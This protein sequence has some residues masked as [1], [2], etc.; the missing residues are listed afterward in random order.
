[1]PGKK[2]PNT[3]ELDP[4][5]DFLRSFWAL[6]HAIERVSIRMESVLGLTAQQRFVMRLVAKL[7]GIT[8]GRLAE[9]LHVDPGSITAVLK[10]LEQREFIV[11]TP[12]A[13]DRRRITLTLSARGRKLN[14]PS[15]VSVEHAVAVAL[16]QTTP[17]DLAAVRRIVN[18]LV[19]ALDQV[20]KADNTD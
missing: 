11:R 8:P 20:S 7:P 18:R 10:R 9:L 16:E 13:I 12:D 1:M 2:E 14:A 5:L 6:N 19:A 15:P 17:A 4:A 3:P